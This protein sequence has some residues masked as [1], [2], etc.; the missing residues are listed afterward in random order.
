MSDLYDLI[1]LIETLRERAKAFG[2]DLQKSETLT[3]YA[4]VDPVLRA[5]GWATDDP[6]QVR[7]EFAAGTMGGGKADYCLLD[8]DGKPRVLLEVKALHSPKGSVAAAAVVTYAFHLLGSGA[9]GPLSVGITDGLKW[10]FYDIPHLK[11]PKVAVNLAEGTP[12]EGAVRLLGALW[13]PLVRRADVPRVEPL[14]PASS[15]ASP[16]GAAETIPLNRLKVKTGDPP[17][18]LLL[19]PDGQSRELTAWNHLLIEI[20]NYVVD[21]GKLTRE[22]CPIRSERA[23]DRY[24]VTV[25]GIHLRGHKFMAPKRLKNGL[26]LE[27]YYDVHTIIRYSVFLLTQCGEDPATYRVVFGS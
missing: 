5:M 8:A 16:V 14:K 2:P 13:Q 15:T 12:A 23:R 10:E 19:L 22:M 25:D 11:E 27:T 18:R 3:R 7:V 26:W 17:P 1:R 6:S 24:L 9:G 4:L 20:A 21:L